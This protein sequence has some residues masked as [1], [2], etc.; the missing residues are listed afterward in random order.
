MY[1]YN[2]KT[3]NNIKDNICL[4]RFISGPKR[5]LFYQKKL[6]NARNN[7]G[8]HI[9]NIIF[10]TSLTSLLCIK[11]NTR[12]ILGKLR[13]ILTQPDMSLLVENYNYIQTIVFESVTVQL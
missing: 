5:N 12:S 4:T 13:I 8:G 9:F 10:K 7:R 1:E 2:L 3:I 6:P 11:I